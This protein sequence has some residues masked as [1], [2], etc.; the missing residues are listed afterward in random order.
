MWGRFY[1][2]GQ[3]RNSIQNILVHQSIANKFTNIFTEMVMQKLSLI[4][5]SMDE[6]NYGCI[7]LLEEI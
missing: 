4:N 2:T 7:K 6:S 1:N 3:S 5:P